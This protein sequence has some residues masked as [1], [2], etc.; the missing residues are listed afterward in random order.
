MK[1]L[2]SS[3][4]GGKFAVFATCYDKRGRL[5]SSG[6][7]DYKKS[8]PLMKQLSMQMLGHPER[9]YLHAEVQALLRA[10]DRKVWRMQVLR[11][12]S[13]GN[14]ALAKPCEICRKAIELWGVKEL[15][16]SNSTIELTKEKL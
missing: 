8:H 5:I 2:V 4:S 9:M 16:Y 14:P 12:D 3:C 11:F 15:H 6:M 1:A 10:G 7:N 13:K